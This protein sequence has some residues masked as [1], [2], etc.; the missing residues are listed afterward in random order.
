MIDYKDLV[1]E[2]IAPPQETIPKAARTSS[3]IILP[4]DDLQVRLKLRALNH[5]ITLFG[6]GV[7]SSNKGS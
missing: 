6:E 7:S 2:P 1:P 4:T 3:I 5:P